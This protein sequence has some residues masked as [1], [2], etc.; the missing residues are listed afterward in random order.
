MTQAKRAES[1]RTDNSK[2][3]Q[4]PAFLERVKQGFDTD[5]APRLAENEEWRK[6]SR[7]TPP[8]VEQ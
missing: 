4:Y 7:S 6:Q 5:A 3:F 1:R 2:P 8:L